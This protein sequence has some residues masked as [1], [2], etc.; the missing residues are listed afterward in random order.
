[1]QLRGWNLSRGHFTMGGENMLRSTC[2]SL[3][4]QFHHRLQSSLDALSVESFAIPA[5]GCTHITPVSFQG[6]L[7]DIILGFHP[8]VLM[9]GS[10]LIG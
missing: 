4:A 6:H 7:L 1:M 2:T 10:A 9:V 5:P 3:P 8:E